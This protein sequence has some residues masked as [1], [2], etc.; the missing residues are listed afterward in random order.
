MN[1]LRLQ[2]L[3][4]AIP[5]MAVAWVGAIWFI[6]RA[7]S[8]SWAAVMWVASSAPDQVLIRAQLATFPER[9]SSR[10]P[11][12]VTAQIAQPG[13][14]M[15]VEGA[16][17]PDGIVDFDVA[18]SAAV[19]QHE[20][21]LFTADQGERLAF[22]RW[23]QAELTAPVTLGESPRPVTLLPS[24]PTFAWSLRHGVLTVPVPDELRLTALAPGAAGV[25]SAAVSL[26][27]EGA[28]GPNGQTQTTLTDGETWPVT[29]HHHVVEA[30]LRSTSVDGVESSATVLLPVVAGA[31]AARVERGGLQ[32]ISP[33]PRAQAY[34]A[35]SRADR[36]I[37]L[38]RVALQPQVDSDGG[39]LHEGRFALSPRLLAELERGPVWAVTSSEPDFASDAAVGWPL[40]GGEQRVAKFDWGQRFDGFAQQARHVAERRQMWR[41]Y[42][43]SGLGLACLLELG[44]VWS[45]AQRTPLPVGVAGVNAGR[46]GWLAAAA[47]CVILGF[48]GLG[49]LFGFW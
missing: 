45:F 35:I 8:P 19:S 9:S 49:T 21:A 43:W 33:V 41:V 48:A 40:S 22:G 13:A 47:G 10:L 11:S 15:L 3:L 37:A 38:G 23:T 17:G 4:L 6:G 30:T 18:S 1:Q 25:S 14:P 34:V 28:T 27:L 32:V 2:Q 20:V 16:V 29:P 46:S 44:L 12:V 26:E 24:G 7:T 36:V 5:A 42:A 31:I 39:V